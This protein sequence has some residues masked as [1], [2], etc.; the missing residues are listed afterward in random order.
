MSNNIPRSY[1]YEDVMS[2]CFLG[3]DNSIWAYADTTAKQTFRREDRE[4]S[5]QTKVKVIPT[6]EKQSG[7]ASLLAVE[8]ALKNGR[9]N[10]KPMLRNADNVLIEVPQNIFKL[11]TT[12]GKSNTHVHF[13]ADGKT[14]ANPYMVR[15]QNPD[16]TRFLRASPSKEAGS[17]MFKVEFEKSWRVE[18]EKYNL[19]DVYIST[20]I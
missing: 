16:R 14:R 19:W 11:F 2:T 5:H 18:L 7:A 8:F 12:G 20:M 10:T 15:F 4:I 17:E 9:L 3:S 13:Q 6:A 1:T